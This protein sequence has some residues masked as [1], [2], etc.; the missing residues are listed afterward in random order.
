M[1]LTP[2]FSAY[3]DVLRLLAALAV[4]LAHLDMDGIAMGWIP[5]ARYSH[6]A[7]MIFF[8]MSGFIIHKTTIER[9]RSASEY[10][11]ARAA[12]IYSVAIPAI[13]LSMLVALWAQNSPMI[14]ERALSNW[15]PDG[16]FDVLSS[17]LFLNQSWNNP[18]FL[19]LNVPFWSLCYEVWYYVIFGVFVFAPMRWRWGLASV[20]GLIAGPAILALLPVWLMGVALSKWGS[21]LRV[22]AFAAWAMFLGGFAIIATIDATGIDLAISNHLKESVPGFWRLGSASRVITDLAIG[23]AL[24]LNL[25]AFQHLGSGIER[26]FAR[27]RPFVGY[28][29]GYSFSLYLFHRPITQIAGQLFPVPEGERGLALCAAII[30]AALCCLM[31]A[32]TERRAGHWRALFGGNSALKP[33]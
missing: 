33:A 16:A 31:G 3:L 13:L 32:L 12:R 26:G 25:L 23:L 24:C 6:E 5:L 10:A 19:T 21:A 29:A 2:G 27:I 18:V 11:I 28:L 9:G 4:L 14:D 15:H 20:A 7:V 1:P 22:G 8:V 17:V 30:I